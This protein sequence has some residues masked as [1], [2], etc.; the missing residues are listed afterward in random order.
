MF[1]DIAPEIAIAVPLGPGDISY[2]MN[3]VTLHSLTDFE[4]W[5]DP[6]RK[7]HLLRLWIN[8]GDRRPLP[9]E[10]YK[11][12]QGIFDETTKFVAPLDAE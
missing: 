9:P 4:D 5:P 1:R 12:S 6:E 3:H 8:T 11:F 7:R 2:G 10:I